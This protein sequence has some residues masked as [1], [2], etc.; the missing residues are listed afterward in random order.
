MA[1]SIFLKTKRFAA[2]HRSTFKEVVEMALRDF[3]E[4]KKQRKDKFKLKLHTVKGKGLAPGLQ[5]GDW[6]TLSNLIYEGRGG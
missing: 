6:S 3:F 5:E 4:E 2:A 1:D